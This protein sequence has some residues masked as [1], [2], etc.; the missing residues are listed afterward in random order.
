MLTIWPT[1]IGGS[2]VVVVVVG[3]WVVVVVVV[4]EVQAPN[5]NILT[6]R[7]MIGISN[8]LFIVLFTSFFTR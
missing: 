1:F 2:G 3:D 8:T 5:I 7:M 6:I 4:D